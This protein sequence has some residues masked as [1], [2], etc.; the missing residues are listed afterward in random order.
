MCERASRALIA[1]RPGNQAP[2]CPWR[3]HL[4]ARG[5]QRLSKATCS[6]AAWGGPGRRPAA[7]DASP[8]CCSPARAAFGE[9]TA[10]MC[11]FN[12]KDGFLGAR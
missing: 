12:V 5:S 4:P 6:P 10:E 9:D 1:A 2:R 11:L 8:L 3:R 7:V